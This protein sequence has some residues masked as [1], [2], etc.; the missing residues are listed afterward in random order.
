MCII[1]VT[2][3][4]IFANFL[5]I[6]P[7][8]VA[9]SAFGRLTKSQGNGAILAVFFNIH[10]HHV[11]LLRVV[12]RN[13]TYK[14]IKVP[15]ACSEL[16]SKAFE[17]DMKMAEPID[18]PLGMMN[19]LGPRNSVTYGDNP[20]RGRGNFGGNVLDK[21]KTPVNYKLVWSMQRH[22][23]DGQT[24]DCKRWTSLLSATKEGHCTSRRSLIST[25]PYFLKK[26]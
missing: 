8:A 5:R 1:S 7:T 3:R 19:G 23:H 4:V 12:I 18:M 16:Y 6:F 14:N 24:L 10:H 13:R 20:Q 15:E 21:P 22:A 11:R 2:T 25:M 17:T 9:R 26:C